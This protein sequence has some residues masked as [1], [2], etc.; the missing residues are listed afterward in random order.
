MLIQDVTK[1]IKY[2]F[3][4]SVLYL[5]INANMLTMNDQ[6]TELQVCLMP[7]PT[8]FVCS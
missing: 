3:L 6:L 1:Y 8:Y 7:L 5:L 2:Y 4:Y